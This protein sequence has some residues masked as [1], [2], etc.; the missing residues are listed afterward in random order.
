MLHTILAVPW[1][2]DD[3]L[4]WNLLCG[5]VKGSYIIIS[6]LKLFFFF[7]NYGMCQV[8]SITT[9]ELLLMMG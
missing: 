9:G 5:N 1:L 2:L 8:M 3:K 4:L 6:G 7:L